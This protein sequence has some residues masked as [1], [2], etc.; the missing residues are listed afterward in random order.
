[1]PQVSRLNRDDSEIG[2]LLSQENVCCF[3]LSEP[4]GR[5][6]FHIRRGEWGQHKFLWC[7]FWFNGPLRQY[8]SLYRA[9]S[10]REKE[11]RKDRG[12]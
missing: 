3:N 8:F 1:M 11:G 4:S 6:D 9:V 5:D 12:K 10:Q 2:C 7:C